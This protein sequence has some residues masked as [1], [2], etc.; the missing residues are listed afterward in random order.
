MTTDTQTTEQRA[1]VVEVQQLLAEVRGLNTRAQDLVNCC[2]R[3]W[4]LQDGCPDCAP[5]FDVAA[6][7]QRATLKLSYAQN[8]LN[9]V[10]YSKHLDKAHA[11]AEPAEVVVPTTWRDRL[12]TPEAASAACVAVAVTETVRAVMEGV[13]GDYF[14]AAIAAALATAFAALAVWGWLRR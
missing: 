12:A 4:P 7:L 5:W 9:L 1:A 10:E 14:G 8:R 3:H 2:P 6:Q 11:P 13:A